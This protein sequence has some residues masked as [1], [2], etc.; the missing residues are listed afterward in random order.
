MTI[1]ALTG[2]DNKKKASKENFAA[3]IQAALEANPNS[4]KVCTEFSSPV[5]EREQDYYTSARQDDFFKKFVLLKDKGYLTITDRPADAQNSEPYIRVAVTDKFISDF[6]EPQQKSSFFATVPGDIP[7]C[8]ATARFKEVTDFTEP[9][10]A[11]GMKVSQVDY[12]M[13]RTLVTDKPWLKD[14]ELLDAL[15][16]RLSLVDEKRQVTA[17]LK[18]SGWVVGD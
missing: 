8:Y 10:E 12:L 18:D 16:L 17:V 9:S 14:Q 1:L 13:S 3:A 4:T 7:V 5:K 11:L 15:G 6:G 2:C